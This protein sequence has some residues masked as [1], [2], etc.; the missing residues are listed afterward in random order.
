MHLVRLFWRLLRYR[1]AVMLVLFLLVGAAATGNLG[2]HLW[3][4]GLAA[5]A[6]AS[7]Y[8]SATSSNDLA[9]QEIDAVNH[10]GH[11]ARPLISGEATRAQ[12][13]Q[14]FGLASAIAIGLAALLSPP[15][16]GIM[17]IS[18]LVNVAYSLPPLR[19]SF[20]TWLAP[21][22]LG[23]GYVGVPFALGIAVVHGESS[24]ATRCLA[25]ACY[26]LFVGRIVL[27]D[28]RDRAGDAKYGKPTLLLAHGKTTTCLVSGLMV[29]LGL[30]LLVI[31]RPLQPVWLLIAPLTLFAF[32]LIQLERLW[33]AQVK[34][35][36]IAIG[37]GAKLGNAALIIL[38]GLMILDRSGA[39]LGL[40][41]TF[42]AAMLAITLYAYAQ[43][44]MQ[45]ESAVNS[46]RG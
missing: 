42:A 13:W 28:F 29:V 37:I 43:L 15:A 40:R 33:R 44:V 5:A 21:L 34:Q 41:T 4:L 7:G 23:V 31:A 1:V 10:A 26:C 6:L 27:K 39:S 18:I 19:L 35:E 38:L 8:V 2:L 12:M 17:V 46:Y 20:R 22:V 9:D 25:A 32:V 36:Q 30:V 11:R 16:A 3:Q 45:P 14:L 24:A